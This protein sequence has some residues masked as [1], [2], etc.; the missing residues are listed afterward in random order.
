MNACFL[1]DSKENNTGQA[2][3]KELSQRFHIAENTFLLDR[4]L[5]NSNDKETRKALKYKA[6]RV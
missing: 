5:D 6:F 4:K 1:R 2:G 3:S